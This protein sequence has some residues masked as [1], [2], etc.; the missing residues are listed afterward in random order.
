[1]DLRVNTLRR[2]REEVLAALNGEG[3]GAKSTAFSPVGIRLSTRMPLQN[4]PMWKDGTLEIQD[5]GSHFR[6]LLCNAQPGMA[7]IDYCAGAGGKSLILAETMKNK[8]RLVLFDIQD[9]GLKRSKE[10]LNRAGVHN[11]ELRP[12]SEA[13]WFKA[14]RR[15]LIMF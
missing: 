15:V 4:L 5:E 8:G 12:L 9:W 3:L 1:M 6:A 10:R 13:T 7:I 14:K 2:T 11:Y